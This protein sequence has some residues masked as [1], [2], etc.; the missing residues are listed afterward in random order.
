MQRVIPGEHAR[1]NTS[2]WTLPDMVGA[3]GGERMPALSVAEIERIQQSAYDEAFA[4]GKREGYEAGF[5]E[6]R[7]AG[8]QQGQGEVS[9]QT[10]RLKGLLD[11]L[12]VPAGELDDAVENELAQLALAIARQII[13]RELQTQP[14]EIVGVIREAIGLLP[15]STREVRIQVHPEDAEFLRET[16]V[17]SESAWRLV[18]DPA[19]SRGGCLISA[20]ASR[21]DATVEHRLAAVIADLLG[22]DRCPP[23]ESV[24]EHDA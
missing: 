14:G 6:G 9:T 19:V 22:D 23:A 21:L 4:Q 17:E 8:L 5:A 18:E 1:G 12:A 20:E 24:P 11:H 15:L 2:L 16:L 10:R 7:G 13:R 3:G